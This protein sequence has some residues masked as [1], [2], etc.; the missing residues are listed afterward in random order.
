MGEKARLII[1]QYWAKRH[2]PDPVTREHALN[3]V[4]THIIM[5]RQWEENPIGRLVSK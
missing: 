5:L 1:R 4:K 3:L 2:D